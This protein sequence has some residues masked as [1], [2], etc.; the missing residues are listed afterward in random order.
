MSV[1][2]AIRALVCSVAALLAPAAESFADPW[3]VGFEPYSSPFTLSS[4]AY[5]VAAGDVNGDG[6][7]DI[8]VGLSGSGEGNTVWVTH[9]LDRGSW[10]PPQRLVQVGP[11]AGALAV[12]DFDGDGKDDVVEATSAGVQVFR[13]QDGGLGPAAI[14]PG[15]EGVY[16]AVVEV[17]DV[18]A[19]G[20][21]DV[22]TDTPVPPA[23]EESPPSKTTLFLKNPTGS[24]YT[25]RDLSADS[26]Q[27]IRIGDLTGDGRADIVTLVR[28]DSAIHLFTQ[29]P[30]GGFDQQLVGLPRPLDA[31]LHLG[32]GDVTGDGRLDLVTSLEANR[33]DAGMA[34]YRQE[35]GGGLAPPVV[36]PAYE[37]PRGA[38]IA[39]MNGDGR[40]DV[41]TLHGYGDGWTIGVFLQLPSG[42]L[43]Q[44]RLFAAPS[45]G[46]F[47]RDALVVADVS[48]D[49]R[50]DVVVDHPFYV[51]RQ[52]SSGTSTCD[53]PPSGASGSPGTAPKS[54]AS[55]G[56]SGVFGFRV[57]THRTAAFLKRGFRLRAGCAYACVVRAELWLYGGGRSRFAAVS[58]AHLGPAGRRTMT[59]RPPRSKRRRASA[60]RHPHLKLRFYVTDAAGALLTA[61]QR[62]V[63]LH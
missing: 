61:R 19:D 54:T 6:R 20:R 47:D 32:L 37:I 35:P 36:Y 51:Q 34:V 58:T 44:E 21:S 53:R 29:R 12:L 25:G 48:C 26:P 14:L 49:G 50:P 62:S 63:R 3:Q 40:A 55:P 38:R 8:V 9:Q 46:C 56:D 7:N 11:Y 28:T 1:G 27:E 16:G 60:R 42:E 45:C 2:A 5:G 43:D 10:G 15:T 17:A 30:D 24:G 18:N 33:P 22:V 31:T 23:G 52:S 4:Y 41:V 39:D 57:L 59:L 13:Q